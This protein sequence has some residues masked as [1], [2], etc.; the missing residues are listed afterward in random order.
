MTDEKHRHTIFI[1]FLSQHYQA[2]NL[3]RMT[4]RTTENIPK[5]KS[6][7]RSPCEHITARLVCNW[8]I[9]ITKFS[10]TNDQADSKTSC[11]KC[12][13]IN[14]KCG[15]LFASGKLG[16]LCAFLSALA[17]WRQWMRWMM[18]L[19]YEWCD[20]L[21]KHLQLLKHFIGSNRIHCWKFASHN[22]SSIRTSM[23]AHDNNDAAND[24]H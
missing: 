21:H 12:E 15:S 4:Y 7:L 20:Y 23:A 18:Y 13:Y 3:W 6:L 5:T 11:N 22:V 9:S 14:M 17:Q 10:H 1:F 24:V 16:K 8:N 2:T 19:M